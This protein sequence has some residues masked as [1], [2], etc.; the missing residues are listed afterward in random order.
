ML[1]SF[2]VDHMPLETLLFQTGYL[3]IKHATTIGNE[4]AYEIGYPNL[5]V[6][7]SLNKHLANIG[8]WNDSVVNR[9]R[10]R[11]D[12][13]LK[14]GDLQPLEG[15]FQSIFA[16]IPY[17][18]YKKHD[19]HRYEGFYASIVYSYLVSLG[20]DLIAEDITNHGKIDLTLRLADKIIIFE[21]KLARYG[22]AQEAI[23]QI[24]AK[25]YPQKYQNEA[26]P[27]HLVGISFDEV[28]KN[29]AELVVEEGW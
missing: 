15:F 5:E 8:A 14:S 25:Q 20:Y 26:K 4:F 29:V 1:A 17:D 9:H 21:F 12:R 28:D 22:S 19:M 11:L 23:E 6:K 13:V 7:M 27:I 24:K 2:D 10:I 18:W 3:T 16:S